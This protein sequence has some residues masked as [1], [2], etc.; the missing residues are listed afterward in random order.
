MSIKR[1]LERG[2]ILLMSDRILAGLISK[3]LQPDVLV[4]DEAHT[5]LRNPSTT[6]YKALA[7]IQTPR[8]IGMY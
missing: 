8:K 1:W 7:N 4:L 6:M 2:G 3:N 5:M